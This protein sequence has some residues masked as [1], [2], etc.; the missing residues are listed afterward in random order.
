METGKFCASLLIAGVLTAPGIADADLQ[1]T[2]CGTS[3]PGSQ[4]AVLGADLDCRAAPAD[5]AVELGNDAVL[6]LAGHTIYGKT[7]G[8][9]CLRN[10]TVSGPGTIRFATYGVRGE[11]ETFVSD[12]LIAENSVG[13]W[14]WQ[15]SA[16]RC[17]VEQNTDKGVRAITATID[18]STVRQNDTGILVRN[19]R[20]SSSVVSDNVAT[21][22]FIYN[23]TWESYDNGPVRAL[24]RNSRIENNGGDGAW[25]FVTHANN[26]APSGRLDL[27]SSTI[28]GNGGNGVNGFNVKVTDTEVSGNGGDGIH[29]I[30][31]QATDATVFGNAGHGIHAP[32]YDWGFPLSSRLVRGRVVV[33]RTSVADNG[34]DGV[35]TTKVAAQDAS[36]SSNGGDPTCPACVDVR[37]AKRPRFKRTVCGT[38]LDTQDPP[39]TWGVCAND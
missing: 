30:R 8:V 10:C 7:D 12:L 39:A 18:D 27:Y 31:A 24:V 38:S 22:V 37:A 3:V 35:N 36:V 1:V 2:G 17:S 4:T 6:Q 20:L 13:V 33:L 14:A 23:E 16:S 32:D 15:L 25:A 26:T 34:G 29:A 28:A 11:L 21:G 19:L 9:H 5:F